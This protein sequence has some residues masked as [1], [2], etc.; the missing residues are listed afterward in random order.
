LAKLFSMVLNERLATFADSQGLRAQGQAGFV[1][2]RGAADHMFVLRH[3]ID[4]VRLVRCPPGQRRR[5]AF[6]PLS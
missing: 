3:L 2:G 1:R 5:P 6:S 4:R